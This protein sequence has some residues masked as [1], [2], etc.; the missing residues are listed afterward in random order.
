M[1]RSLQQSRIVGGTGND[2][3]SGGAN[4]DAI[5][6]VSG[7]NTL[8]G[9]I[10]N[11]VL[12]GGS[13]DDASFG[14]DGDDEIKSGSGN[15]ILHGGAGADVLEGGAG[16]DVYVDGEGA[17]MLTDYQ[18]TADK[19]I[20]VADG[21]VDVVKGFD[22]EDLIYFETLNGI[23][24]EETPDGLLISIEGVDEV[25]L[26]NGRVKSLDDLMEANQLLTH[27]DLTQDLLDLI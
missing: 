19:F 11:D 18:K 24:G 14:G 27:T 25:M 3:L 16:D 13:D 1:G 8:D 9:G 5:F 20:F 23:A 2:Q 15:D 4:D 7:S 6:G 10:G 26:E 17:D 21:E 12:T 22:A